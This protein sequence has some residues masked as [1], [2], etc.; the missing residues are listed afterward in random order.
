[1]TRPDRDLDLAASRQLDGDSPGESATRVNPEIDLRSAELAVARDA[2]SG[3]DGGP[4][5]APEIR[6]AQI[7]AAAELWR[8]PVSGEAPAPTP[9][10]QDRHS[11]PWWHRWGPALGSTAMVTVVL[12]GAASVLRP[13]GADDADDAATET[14]EFSEAASETT[15]ADSGAFDETA[16]REMSDE[17]TSDDE[18]SEEQGA[19]SIDDDGDMVEEGEASGEAGDLTEQPAPL[20]PLLAEPFD[21]DGPDLDRLIVETIE[22][23]EPG[24]ELENQP[25]ACANQA[26]GSALLHRYGVVES[27]PAELVVTESAA[28]AEAWLFAVEDCALLAAR[29][30]YTS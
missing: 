13:R 3:L 20:V 28:G 15:K 29:T 30:P 21:L 4:A 22:L 27:E 16:D 10:R 18:M 17:A 26:D 8:P 23:R 6:L 11:A 9:K 12:V 2:V 24:L 5:P 14:A 7:R 25:S 19:D 1:M